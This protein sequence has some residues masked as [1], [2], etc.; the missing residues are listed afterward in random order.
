MQRPLDPLRFKQNRYERPNQPWVCGRAAEGHGCPLGPDERGN[1]RATGE[2]AP[3]KRGDRWQCTRNEAQGGKCEHGPLPDGT[4][5]HLIPPCQPVPSLRRSRGSLVWLIVALTIGAGLI[6]FG[7]SWNHRWTDPGKLT[8]AHATSAAKCSDCHAGAAEPPSRLAVVVPVSNPRLTNSALCLKCHAQL[9]EHPFHP[10][11]VAP[12]QLTALT[13]AEKSRPNESR[14]LVLQAS[15]VL[16]GSLA[17]SDA[18]ACATCHQEHHG[19][20]FPLQQLSDTQCQTCHAVQF[21]S[22]EHGHPEFSDYPYRGRTPIFFDH[23]SH[24]RQH[25]GEMNEHAPTSCQ[26]CHETDSAGRFMQVK[27]FA[28]TCAACHEPQIQGAGMSVKGVAFFTVPGI[29]AETLASKGISVGEWPKFADGKITPY[30][31][32]LLRRDP[33]LR[34][35][36]EKLRGVDLL[37]LSKASPEQLAAAEQLA[38]GV[39][40]LLFHLVVEGQSYLQQQLAGKID[41]AGIE[42]PQAALV[43]AQQEW[44]PH[45]LTEV[46]NYQN[47]VKPPLPE[48]APS[49]PAPAA[50]SKEKPASGDDDLSAL[51]EPSPS[52][53]KATATDD[54]LG[55]DDLTAEAAATP[56]PS[57]VPDG[58][59]DLAGGDL[60][61]GGADDQTAASPTTPTPVPAPEM[62]SPAE[63][64]AAGGW[65]RP[66]ESF[67]LYYRPTGHADTFLYAWLNTAAKLADKTAPPAAH[68]LFRQLADPQAVGLCLKCHSVNTSTG[69][70]QVNWLP[71]EAQP[72]QKSFTTFR[73]ATHLS[74]FG[75]TA[76]QTCHTINPQAEPAKFFRGETGALAERDPTQFQSNF[77]P[78]SKT[79]CVECHQPK[80]AGDSCLLCHR[81]HAG[82]LTDQVAGRN[83]L[84]PLLGEK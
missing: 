38:W 6:L 71:A 84:R 5:A 69:L 20:N 22:F 36:L 53:A 31:E 57:P 21:A 11:S 76:C 62:K 10:H 13:K 43:A 35:P 16:S 3:A 18:L 77:L 44:M 83:T 15:Q 34:D 63:W 23:A 14:P 4:C 81:Y 72:H 75:N 45:L 79:R 29:D 30:Q 74:L 60:L 47:G 41:P 50:L 27:S 61:A 58:N 65:F 49:T 52:P 78:L 25:F 32:V 68:V 40:K 2:C 33:A 42:I 28:K 73:H 80:I 9:G 59:D 46:T 17:H 19:R 39:K 55:G 66:P 37:D 12:G 24:L 7:G 54:S 8:S 82:S 64:V 26:D 1:C 51:A 70:T 48:I 67:T 56:S